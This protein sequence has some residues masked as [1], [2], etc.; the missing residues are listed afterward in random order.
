MAAP[1]G[2]LSRRLARQGGVLLDVLTCVDEVGQFSL[3]ITAGQSRTSLPNSLLLKQTPVWLRLPNTHCWAKSPEEL[4]LA[5]SPRAQAV[6]Q[7]VPLAGGGEEQQEPR[8]LEE[9][10]AP[11]LLGRLVVPGWAAHPLSPTAA[12]G[13]PEA[14]ASQHRC[15]STGCIQPCCKHS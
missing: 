2:A 9:T 13:G 15:R 14:G 4:C 1:A 7:G 6:C 8:A 3:G 5:L 10:S 11:C 12:A